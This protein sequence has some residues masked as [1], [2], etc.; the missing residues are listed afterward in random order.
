MPIDKNNDNYGG[1]DKGCNRQPVN[2]CVENK[3]NVFHHSPFPASAAMI[4]SRTRYGRGYLRSASHF[5]SDL[6]ASRMGFTSDASTIL[7]LGAVIVMADKMRA[8]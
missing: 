8:S 5:K 4:G 3:G 7:S 1:R 6:M 2:E